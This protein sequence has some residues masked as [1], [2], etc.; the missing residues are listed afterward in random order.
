MR[1]CAQRNQTLG[2]R[3]MLIRSHRFT[4]FDDFRSHVSEW[5]TEPVQL[6]RGPL[7]IGWDSIDLGDLRLA[8]LRVNR[9]I[10][11]SSHVAPGWLVFVVVL[12]SPAGKRWSGIEVPAGHLVILYPGRQH[13]SR[14]AEGWESFEVSVSAPRLEAIDPRL[15]ELPPDGPPPERCVLPLNARLVERFRGWANAL[16]TRPHP[17]A[18]PALTPWVAA[19]VCEHTL[20]LLAAAFRSGWAQ[21]AAPRLVPRYGLARLALEHI[22]RQPYLA[23]NVGELADSLHTTPRALQYAF[24]SA[25]GVSPARY[26]LARRLDRVRHALNDGVTPV[27]R[28]ALDHEFVH[29]GRLAGAYRDWFGELPS[30]TLRAAARRS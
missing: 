22:D 2:T 4:D 19:A 11:D 17:F 9:V 20:A 3:Q 14:L 26:L 16:F 25:V 30:Q 6:S 29:L 12:G 18:D 13:R 7:A 24:R 28:A 15:A 8:R 23:T 5:D 27:T 21:A 1:T 10:G